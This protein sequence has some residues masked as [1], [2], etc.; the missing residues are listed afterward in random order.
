MLS[1]IDCRPTRPVL[2]YIGLGANLGEKEKALQE[3]ASEI[4]A[5]DKT[6]LCEVSSLYVTEPI[7]ATG[8]DYLNA[9]IS[10]ATELTARELLHALQKI[11]TQHGRI[12]PKG[13]VNAPR[14][15]DLDLLLY[16]NITSEEAELELPHPRLLTRAF[17][18]VPL[19]EITSEAFKIAGKGLDE[20]IQAVRTQRIEKHVDRKSFLDAVQ[21]KIKLR[22]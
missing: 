5:L 13:V 15:L 21:T 2:A 20:W 16:G 10:V 17:V 8:D 1:T 12:R 18:L 14:T 22:K 11:E 9:V 4:A 19:R 6:T 7:E 3:A